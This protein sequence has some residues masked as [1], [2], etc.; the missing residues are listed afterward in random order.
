MVLGTLF[1]PYRNDCAVV[2]QMLAQ[3][4]LELLVK[5]LR[6]SPR[7]RHTS[8]RATIDGPTMTWKWLLMRWC[9]PAAA[10]ILVPDS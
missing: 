7:G 6:L 10:C 5:G 3:G 2:L 4:L 9:K 8:E 1:G